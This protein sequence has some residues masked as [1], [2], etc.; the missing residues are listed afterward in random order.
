VPGQAWTMTLFVL[1]CIAGMTDPWH[2]A[3]PLVEMGSHELF[4]GSG[5]EL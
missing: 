2:C 5:L 3:K 4:A 1:S